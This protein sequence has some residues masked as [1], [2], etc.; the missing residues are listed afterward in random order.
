MVPS[1]STYAA[2]LAALV[3]TAYSIPQAGTFSSTPVGGT[4]P[5]AAATA[6]TVA[7]N[8]SPDLCS[9]SYANI[10]H[11]GAHDSSFLRD[12]STQDSIAGNQFFNATVALDAGIRM[13]QVQV[14]DLNGTVEMCHTLCSLL[15]AGPLLNW[16]S[17]IKI[18]MDSHPNEVVTLLIVNSDGNS[19]SDF[20]NI[21]QQSGIAQYGF[22]PTGNG[23]P[24]LQSMILAKT[25]LVTFIASITPSSQFPYLLNEFDHVFETAFGVTSQNGFNCSI[26]RPSTPATSNAA[27]SAGLLPLINHFL[28]K[29]L[30]SSI[31]IPD[32]DNIATTNNPSTS[33]TGALG[34]HIETCNSEWAH[35]PT[36]VLVDFW[37]EGPSIDAADAINGITHAVG[38]KNDTASSAD[39]AG[40]PTNLNEAFRGRGAAG[41]GRE[42]LIGFFVV[43]FMLA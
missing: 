11:I 8:N 6:P 18:W 30:G 7:C 28:D 5:T 13:L 1:L 37:N 21:F 32:V 22:T 20:G 14:H 15:D 4:V 19:V 36:F 27:L 31:T 40:S 41:M 43:V 10:T 3:G 17:D 33:T 24:T 42:A 34:Q 23:W 29:D 38:R 9:R 35:L 16:L 2:A 12:A 26:D 39:T 25:R